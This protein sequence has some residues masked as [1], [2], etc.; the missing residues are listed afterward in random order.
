MEDH[1]AE[2]LMARSTR[3]QYAQAL[4]RLGQAE[5]ALEIQQ[6]FSDQLLAT[7][8][9]IVVVLD[10]HGD[11]VY[12]NPFMERLSGYRLVEVMERNWFA[13]FLPARDR[14]RIKALFTRAIGGVRTEANI[15]AI[16]TKSGEERLIQWSDHP[17]PVWADNEHW[18]LASG[19]DVTD[20]ASEACALGPVGQDAGSL[21][22]TIAAISQAVEARDPYAAGHQQ[23]VA[24]LA[25][26]IGNRMALS[27]ASLQGLR[28]GGRIHNVGKL[29][30]P[31]TLL[32]KPTRLDAAEYAL[33]QQHPTVGHG[34]L[35][36]TRL[37]RPVIDIVHQHHERLDG[38]GYPQGLKG[39][40][41]CLEARIVAVAD[42]VQAMDSHRAYRGGL[43][44]AAAL[45]EIRDHR[46]S[47]YDA[48][49]VD[50]CLGVFADGFRFR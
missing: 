18:L 17:L 31:A 13:T 26:A 2:R 47:R 8:Q 44:L 5:A 12:I 39:E 34:I 30:V 23:R 21:E 29:Q 20:S 27:E 42:V 15:N 36:D 38:S 3:Q 50:A 10:E 19:V 48:D 25:V 7:M 33:V 37:P 40:Q 1:G 32:T 28:L 35:K 11:I 49:A 22:D 6:V 45:D 4:A 14:E 41:I 46:G 16:V 43:G 24:A 9:A